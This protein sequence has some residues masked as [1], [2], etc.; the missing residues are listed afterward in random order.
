[1]ATNKRERQ[2][3]NRAV[4]QAEEKKQARR[5]AIINRVRR[6]AIWAVVLTALI[7]VSQLVWG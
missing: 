4:K 6:V 5:Q 2:R 1:M 3:E 7:I